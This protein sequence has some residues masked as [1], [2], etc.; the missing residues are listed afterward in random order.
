MILLVDFNRGV[1]N[2]WT[3][4]NFLVDNKRIKS[5][6]WN[7]ILGYDEKRFRTKDAPEDV[8]K[9]Q[10]EVAVHRRGLLFQLFPPGGWG[11]PY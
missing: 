9:R 2:F 11:Y 4:Y 10:K 8:Y 6:A 1:S 5:G 7:T 3:N